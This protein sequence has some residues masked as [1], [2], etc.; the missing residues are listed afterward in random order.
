MKFSGFKPLPPESLPVPKPNPTTRFV[1]PIGRKTNEIITQEIRNNEADSQKAYALV[2]KFKI[3]PATRQVR[4]GVSLPTIPAEPIVDVEFESPNDIRDYDSTGVSGPVLPSSDESVENRKLT[5]LVADDFPFDES[6]LRAVSELV[7][8]QYGCIT[9]AAGTGKTTTL[10]K[11]V[12]ELLTT[13]K[14]EVDM[15]TYFKQSQAEDEPDPGAD[16]DED[17]EVTRRFVPSVCLST[18]TGK[19]S[20]MIKKN[21]PRDWHGNIMTIHRMLAYKPEY[22]EDLNDS[23]QMTKKR[24]FVPTYG[25]DYKLPWDIVIIDEAGMVSVD[26]WMKIYDALTQGCRVYMVGDINQLPPVHGRS[27]FG[28]AMGIWP[29]F[30]LTTIHRQAGANNS[31]VDNAWR[32][33]Q[34]KTPIFDTPKELSWLTNKDTIASLNWM[35]Q[36]KDWKSGGFIIPDDPREASIRIRQALK[37]LQGK[38]YD[39]IRDTVITAINGHDGSQGRL[40]GQIPMNQDLALK[41]NQNPDRFIIDAGRARQNFAV[42]D[43]LMATKNDHEQGITNGMTGICEAIEWNPQYSGDH[44]RFGKVDDVAKYLAEGGQ[45]DEEEDFTLDSLDDLANEYAEKI[46][47]KEAG[48]EKAERG[49]ASH[50]VTVRFGDGDHAFSIAFATLSEVESLSM[51]YVVTCHKMQGG[52]SPHV[53]TIL[54][55]A[56]KGLAL[57]SR[58]WL[59][60]GWTRASEKSILLYTPYALRTA[61]NRQKITGST[62]REKVK[63]FQK[64]Q[65]VKT[66]MQDELLL[67]RAR[68]AV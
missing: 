53:F 18:F 1:L 32:I 38:F 14:K 51:A 68:L 43:K 66:T 46:K 29:S 67:P 23:G 19:A 64:I 36:N 49:P 35:V 48:K 15:S 47:G 26:L 54:H 6:Q 11:L 42:G 30:E 9:G 16:P 59:Y 61:L 37:L 60:T 25:A 2:E 8:N 50:I 13:L 58:E 57:I 31:I 4:F 55:T 12:D 63:S 21:F 7:L 20:Q 28:F 5:K 41:L 45:D 27:I 62:L 3:P 34:G 44:Y 22:L 40:L 24:I 65:N 52:E 39:E 17:Y 33:L 56:H 10:K